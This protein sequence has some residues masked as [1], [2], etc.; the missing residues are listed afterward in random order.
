MKKVLLALLI[1]STFLLN[2][3]ET[4]LEAE[5]YDQLN[6]TV[7]PSN[8]VE[9]ELYAQAVY[10][11]FSSRWPS[12]GY[13][14][15]GLEEGHIQQFDAPADLMTQFTEWGGFFQDY[16]R[17]NF[18]NFISTGRNRSHIEYIRFVT[19]TTKIIDDLKNLDLFSNEQT[20]NHLLGEV[21]MARGWMMYYMLHLYGP[22]PVILDPEKINTEAEADLTRPARADYVSAIANDL[23]FAADN[24]PLDAPDYGR[25]NK[26]LALTALM[27]LY[28]NERDFQN[29][30]TV[31]RE[32]VSMN[33]YSLV[34]DYMSLFT[35]ATERNSE[36]IWAISNTGSSTGRGN[37]GN[38]NAYPY[39]TLP[40]DFTE[41]TPGWASPNA[42]FMATW[43]FYDSFDPEDERRNQL[44][45]SYGS[46]DR[47]N[48]RG[49]VINKYPGNGGYIGNDIPIARYADVLLMLAESINENSGGPTPEA[50]DLVNQIRSRADLGDLPASATA[51]KEAFNDA[52]LE[53]RGKEFLFEGLRKFDLVR[54]GEWPGKVEAVAGKTPTSTPLL[55]IPQ[56]AMD[57]GMAQ[58]DGY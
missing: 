16:S 1:G 21:H 38:F 57:D 48:M 3:C 24:L 4:G 55:P 7:F 13:Q 40:A 20:R 9:A 26:G 54:H 36:T 2:G 44:V 14:I 50:I 8:E 17:A 19:R 37:E 15:F 42:V 31:G 11:P 52:I 43:D 27:R 41:A 5:I 49:A 33:K 30:E 34:D 58:N 18:G 32:I 35:E 47:T 56:W 46:R 51:S 28:L 22:V 12:G 10:K 45:A 25:F 53:E 6:P 29:A 23:R 39:Y